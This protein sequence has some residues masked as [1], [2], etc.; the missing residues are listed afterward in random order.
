[1][2]LW[3]PI[4]PLSV[5]TLGL[6]D[7]DRYPGRCLLV[8]EEH[9]DDMSTMPEKLAQELLVDAR[10]AAR[11]IRAAVGADR[12]NYAVLGNA[13]SHV[14]YHLIPRVSNADPAPGRSPW[15]TDLPNRFL[16]S[17]DRQQIIAAIG[18]ML[19]Q[20]LMSREHA[21]NAETEEEPAMTA[22]LTERSAAELALT[23]LLQER[24]KEAMVSRDRG[25][26]AQELGLAPSGVDSLLW[27]DDWSVERALRVADAL[28][29]LDHRALE[30]I[31]GAVLAP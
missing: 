28:G 20:Q 10:R 21:T 1:M 18:R 11:A 16:H 22:S 24:A 2:S 4:A 30:S 26:V 31:A 17:G 8:L 19:D 13:I 12:I 7:D 29:I 3:H 27:Q 25:D 5:S 15:Q 6:Y 9:Y 14:H 23:R